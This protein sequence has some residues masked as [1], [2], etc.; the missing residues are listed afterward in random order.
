[1][2]RPLPPHYARSVSKFGGSARRSVARLCE[3]T[4]RND[5][6]ISRRI[7]RRARRIVLS[8]RRWSDHLR[9]NYAGQD[10]KRTFA[11]FP[12]L[13]AKC[14]QFPIAADR[15][16]PSQMRFGRPVVV[17]EYVFLL[18]GTTAASIRAR[19]AR[20]LI[21]ALSDDET[22]YEEVVKLQH[23]QDYVRETDPASWQ[24]ISVDIDRAGNASEHIPCAA[25]RLHIT[26]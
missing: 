1:M 8:G 25:H 24:T 16:K 20:L 4:G 13:V 3:I 12:E 2:H 9:Q 17:I 21:R 10:V 19:A 23:V 15:H 22:L 11:R 26:P 6:L 5:N 7:V 14:D 18:P